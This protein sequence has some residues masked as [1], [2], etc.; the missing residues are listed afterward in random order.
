MEEE[1]DLDPQLHKSRK[2]KKKKNDLQVTIEVQNEQPGKLAPLVGY[3]PSG[4]DP[5]SD[6]SPQVKVYRHQK[7]VR[8][9]ELVV[10]PSGSKVDFVGTNYSGE[11]AAGRMCSYAL[12]ILDKETQKLKI[13]PIAANK[14]F[15]LEPRVRKG[16]ESVKESMTPAT[17]EVTSEDRMQKLNNLTAHFGT[18]KA[19]KQAKKAS[20]LRQ[21][22]DPATQ[23]DLDHL[24]EDPS[25]DKGALTSTSAE[26]T[27]NIPPHDL[28]ATTP[29][30]AY[31]L[32]KIIPKGEWDYLL[33]ILELMQSGQEMNPDVYPSFVCNRVYKLDVIKDEAEK[34]K[35]AGILSYI[36]HL[37]NF[38]DRHM[39][40]G[41]S[42][43]S[44]HHNIPSMLFQKFTKMFVDTSKKRLADEKIG[45]LISYV[46]V[47]SLYVDEFQT[48]FT[49]IAKDLKMPV[50][51]LRP[52]FEN[53]GCKFKNRNR[54]TFATLPLPLEF[55]T[56]RK[57][58][59]RG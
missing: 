42:S 38:K 24:L 54:V 45:T 23:Q 14:I 4:Y 37:V 3:F 1:A 6:K 18:S 21:K 51:K 59:R 7:K 34:G 52:Y 43:S 41:H 40:G 11:A 48:D 30:K 15:R 32:D 56:V 46:L 10:S 50:I 16:D 26:T 19:I 5:N 44:K 35:L 36:A 8:R 53:L 49:D 57:R 13:V 33:D 28:S 20:L 27:R 39:L 12:G 17:E 55:P 29:E 58:R 2:K 25:I 22:E 31:P 9:L 47:L